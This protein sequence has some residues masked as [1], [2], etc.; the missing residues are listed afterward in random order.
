MKQNTAIESI[1]RDYGKFKLDIA[2]IEKN[3]FEQ[4]DK[5]F[6]EGIDSKQ[7]VEPTSFML[8]TADKSGR[9]SSRILLL[10]SYDEGGFIFY[11][12]YESHKG[13]DLDENPY[14]AML[15]FYDKYERQIRIEGRIEKTSKEV[16]EAYFKKRP[17]SSRLGAWASQQSQVLKSRFTLIREVA[18]YA[19]KFPMDVP[20]PP[21]WGGY[22]LTPDT[23]EF[24]QGRESRLHDRFQYS[25]Q[26]DGSWK[27]DRLS[28]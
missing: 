15:F 26:E 18:K 12:N 10:K 13:R 22:R 24:W 23:F 9:P 16:S 17:L 19:I 25:L 2:S 11:S 28:P 21:H 7:F 14:A 8:S 6:K 27:I 4:F 20:L 1:R 5:W 3:P